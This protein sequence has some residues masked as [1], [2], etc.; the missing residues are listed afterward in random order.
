MEDKI[1]KHSFEDAAQ[2]LLKVTN[3]IKY[4]QT[5][6]TLMYSFLKRHITLSQG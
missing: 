5:L 4:S 3:V 2:G 6:E 1:D